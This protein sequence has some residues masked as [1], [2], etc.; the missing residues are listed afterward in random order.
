MEQVEEAP[1]N[2]YSPPEGVAATRPVYGTGSS[3]RV[4]DECGETCDLGPLQHLG[5]SLD[6]VMGWDA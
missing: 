3:S 2:I 4:G 6:G 5:H 1:I